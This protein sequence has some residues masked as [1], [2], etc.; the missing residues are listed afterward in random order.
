M[1]LVRKKSITWEVFFMFTAILTAAFLA[2]NIGCFDWLVQRPPLYVIFFLLT[3]ALMAIKV[4][5]VIIYHKIAGEAEAA[6]A[7]CKAA[8]EE[9][10]FQEERRRLIPLPPKESEILMGMR[11]DKLQD[12]REAKGKDALAKHLLKFALWI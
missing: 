5:N 6:E 12:N 7:R 10:K 9:V 1:Y 3:T 4:I 11:N 2:A 8:D